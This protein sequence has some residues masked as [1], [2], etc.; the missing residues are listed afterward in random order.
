MATGSDHYREAELLL[1]R[2]GCDTAEDAYIESPSEANTM[3]LTAAQVHATLALAA[4]TALT[5]SGCGYLDDPEIR[6][7][8]EA[9]GVPDA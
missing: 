3:L 9:A 5:G 2:A 8:R 7:W 6:A 1:N 4:A